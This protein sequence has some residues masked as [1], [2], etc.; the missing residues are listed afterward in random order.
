[1]KTQIRSALLIGLAALVGLAGCDQTAK[2]A[3]EARKKGNVAYKKEAWAE[4][5]AAYDESLKLDP[6][7][8]KLW[9]KK[10]FAHAK[11][12][13]MDEAVASLEKT[14][15]FKTEPAE[16]AEVYRNI[17]NMFVQMGPVERA[18]PYF[19][20]ALEIDPK[21]ESAISWLAE[22]FSQLGGARAQAA[23]AEPA[24]LDKAIAYY[25]QWIKMNPVATTAFLNKR[26]ALIKYT[27]YLKA[28]K[29]KAE[30]D[31]ITNKADPA[32]VAEAKARAEAAQAKFDELKAVFEENNKGLAVAA[33]QNP[34][35]PPGA[36]AKK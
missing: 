35:Q 15:E 33:K 29:D 6:K 34:I 11:A 25:D 28:Q 2:Q 20:K 18:E 3:E 26:I 13:Q 17:G 14:L 32:A 36:A 22:M 30:A 24:H 27:D 12:K 16:K 1:M 19:L 5:A 8:E 10:A 31:A 4:A 21:D 9:Q 23:P 7:Q